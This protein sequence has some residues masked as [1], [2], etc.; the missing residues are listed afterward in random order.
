[1]MGLGTALLDIVAPLF[2]LIGPMMPGETFPYLFTL[3]LFQRSVL[4]ALVVTVV[5]GF[6]GCFLLMRNLALIGDGLAHVSFGGVA[7]GVVLAST[8]PLWY[9]LLFSV[10]ASVLI[11]ELQEREL[12]TGDTA[13]AVFLMPSSSRWRSESCSPTRSKEPCS[14]CCCSSRSSPLRSRSCERR[15][16]SSTWPRCAR[17]SPASTLPCSP[18]WHRAS[19]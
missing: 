19:R 14:R 11:N 12:V 8:A 3:E 2:E 9:A 6:L 5:A 1:M 15:I 17:L 13:I 4:A 16:A 7:L 10:V 18:R